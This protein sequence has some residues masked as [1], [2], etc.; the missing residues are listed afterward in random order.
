[1]A[2]ANVKPYGESWV[3]VT[4]SRAPDGK[5]RAL[6]VNVTHEGAKAAKVYGRAARETYARA[7]A[8]LH[9]FAALDGPDGVL[10]SQAKRGVANLGF[11]VVLWAD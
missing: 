3:S 11:R 2:R 10:V 7:V 8:A 6:E 1:M 9:G 4:V 5:P